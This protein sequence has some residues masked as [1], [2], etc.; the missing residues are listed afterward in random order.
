[1]PELVVAA[2]TDG[3]RPGTGLGDGGEKEKCKEKFMPL[4]IDPVD[5]R[6]NL[7]R[8]PYT[9]LTGYLQMAAGAVEEK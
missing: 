5:E 3:G 6:A 9:V 1:V 4:A 7:K 2:T 8:G